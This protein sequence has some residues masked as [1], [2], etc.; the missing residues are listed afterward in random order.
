MIIYSLKWQNMPPLAAVQ[1]PSEFKK[2]KKTHTQCLSC[3]IFI[4]CLKQPDIFPFHGLKIKQEISVFF[5]CHPSC[6]NYFNI[7]SHFATTVYCRNSAMATN[8]NDD[9]MFSREQGR[10]RACKLLDSPLTTSDTLQVGSM[11]PMCFGWAGLVSLPNKRAEWK[12]AGRKAKFTGFYNSAFM[13]FKII[14]NTTKQIQAS[15]TKTQSENN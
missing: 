12:H 6:L 5:K 3:L 11:L 4:P 14:K 1:T 13:P 10:D 9:V 7:T 15:N 8:C 2:N